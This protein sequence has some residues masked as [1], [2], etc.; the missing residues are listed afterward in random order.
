MTNRWKITLPK[1]ECLIYAKTIFEAKRRFP[2][3][4][5]ITLY[6]DNSYLKKLDE[7]K[8]MST[9]MG[10][11]RLNYE[12]YKFPYNGSYVLV[13]L[14]K[15][16]NGDYYDIL[17]FQ[18]WDCKGQMNPITWNMCNTI[19]FIYMFTDEYL[20]ETQGYI[21][22]PR[23]LKK[24]KPYKFYNKNNEVMW[25]D[26]NGC[27]YTAEKHLLPNKENKA[28]YN[29]FKDNPDAVSVR[30][31]DGRFS[32]NYSIRWFDNIDT[33]KDFFQELHR[34]RNPVF[35]KPSYEIR[36]RGYNR[37][38]PDDRKCILKLPYIN[39]NKELQNGTPIPNIVDCWARK[40]SSSW[41]GRNFDIHDYLTEVI[42]YYIEWLKTIA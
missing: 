32:D 9:F 42:T 15:D 36:K 2:E 25:V 39:L 18:R 14:H 5:D 26:D 35:G 30:F 28:E 40:C 37:K 41:Q 10:C 24:L 7:I 16:E 19:E 29:Q 8:N 20:D 13:R 31:T 21:V 1:G 11:D 38:N 33:F 17:Q 22:T 23:E 3:A 12:V 27:V 4:L 6:K 34:D